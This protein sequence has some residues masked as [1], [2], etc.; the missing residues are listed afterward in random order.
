MRTL[1]ALSPEKRRRVA[2]ETLEIF[3]PI[4]HRLGINS[5]RLELEDLGFAVLYPQRYRVLAEEVKKARGNRKELVLKIKNTI[6]RRLR[7]EGLSAQV[8]GREKH[9]YSLY[10]KMRAKRC[11]FAEIFDVYAFRIIVNTADMAYRVLGVVHNLFKPVPG[12][13]KDYIAIP[14][15]NGYQSLHTVLFGP[16]GIPIEVQIR[17]REMHEIAEA[18]IA[19][20][21]IYK[22]EET[23]L[24]SAHKR[25]REWL[26]GLLEM[27][28]QAGNSE[29]F[30]ENVK[31]DL[32]PDEIYVFTPKGDIMKLPRGAT[33][34]DFAYAVHTDIGAGC[35]AA[36][37]NRQLVPLR[38]PLSTG[39][40]VEVLTAPGAT[41]NPT[42]LSF[43]V[44]AKARAHIRH[45]L[46]NL[47]RDEA[48]ALGQ[49]ML[50]RELERF[51][52]SLETMPTEKLV[53]MLAEL[54][55]N[56]LDTL[57]EDIGLGKRLAPIVARYFLPR[58]N[59]ADESGPQTPPSAPLLIK[60]TEGM[61]VSFPK[62]CHPIP[63]DMVLGYVTAG[64][65]IVIHRQN[66][67][68]VAEFRNH[69]EK[70]VDVEWGTEITKEFPAE[71]RVQVINQRGALAIIAAA[72]AEQ[73][74]NIELVEMSERDERY[75][76]LTLLVAVR[77]RKHL[78]DLIR[79]LR[80][81]KPVSRIGRTL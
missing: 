59:G 34:V 5:I 66:C 30:L 12:R 77:D 50:N 43:V 56:N 17:T 24:N 14:K 49:R 81:L 69:P 8:L 25:A 74:A 57:L 62:C 32:F 73:G 80:L 4:A 36:R 47:Q 52:L 23:S 75:A 60:G 16:H 10:K 44:T 65:G 11:T 48:R 22:A 45:F 29:E 9:L 40:T 15:S 13:F 7:Q 1:D 3:V 27:Q 42:W 38:T 39:E 20:H 70:W 53:T 26:R 63:G 31:I 55:L 51:G 79:A 19:A 58:L 6:K 72:I 37:V 35:V 76:T 2:R 21:W 64:R 68:N 78:A 71:I 54:K 33:V 41:P 18:G 46:K 28:A 67:K 61:V